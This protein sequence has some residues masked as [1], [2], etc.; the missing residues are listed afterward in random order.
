MMDNEDLV[1][2]TRTL[3]WGVLHA[4]GMFDPNELTAEEK[5]EDLTEYHIWFHSGEV[6]KAALPAGSI[7]VPAGVWFSGIT[8]L[9]LH[10]ILPFRIS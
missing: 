5:A 4:I 8:A 1:N 2:A 9:P 7:A 10:S 6:T 3:C